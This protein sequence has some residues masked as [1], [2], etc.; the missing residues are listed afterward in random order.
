MLMMIMRG[1]RV[2]RRGRRME[3]IMHE[4][5]TQGPVLAL[6]EVARDLFSYREG[7]Y[8]RLEAEV[9]GH[10]AV[11]IVGWG[12]EDGQR[13]W[14]LANTWGRGWG[15]RGLF[16]IGWLCHNKLLS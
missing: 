6:M 2:G 10:H 5:M 11:R 15:E 16:R 13:F 3:D 12:V 7:V 14:R 4:V 1:Y 9:V 8:Q